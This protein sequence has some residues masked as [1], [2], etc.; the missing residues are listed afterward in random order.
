MEKD[1]RGREFLV[2]EDVEDI[3]EGMVRVVGGD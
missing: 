2:K 1:G 3:E